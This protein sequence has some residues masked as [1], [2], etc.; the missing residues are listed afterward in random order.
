MYKD[1][2]LSILH[3]NKSNTLDSILRAGSRSDNG[4]MMK[5]ASDIHGAMQQ[6]QILTVVK[7]IHTLF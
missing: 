1:L 5:D 7:R 4:K 6:I 2:F 3:C